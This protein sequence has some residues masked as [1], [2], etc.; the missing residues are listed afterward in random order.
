MRD[1]G[2]AARHV[3]YELG[4]LREALQ[5]MEANQAVDRITLESYLTHVRNL[6]EFFWDGAPNGAVL[7][8]VLAG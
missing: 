3:A 7:P 1:A 6:I 8:R 5:R 2:R 4:M